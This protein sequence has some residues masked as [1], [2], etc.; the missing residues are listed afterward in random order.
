MTKT[1]RIDE[2]IKKYKDSP[3]LVGKYLAFLASELDQ[4]LNDAIA[5]RDMLAEAL[6]MYAWTCSDEEL[7]HYCTS[8]CRSSSVEAQREMKRRK[9]IQ[10]LITNTNTP[11]T[12]IIPEIIDEPRK[13]GCLDG[14]ETIGYFAGEISRL[15][16]KLNELERERDG[17]KEA[18]YSLGET[19]PPS[20]EEL[21]PPAEQLRKFKEMVALENEKTKKLLDNADKHSK[22]YP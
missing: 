19:L 11:E 17:W 9:V 15:R 3:W 7:A 8:A 16:G 18:A 22:M 20:W 13:A 10:T 1:P 2:I 21:Q 12:T 6:N 4:Q 14:L 5:H